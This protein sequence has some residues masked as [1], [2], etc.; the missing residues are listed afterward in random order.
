MSRSALRHLCDVISQKRYKAGTRWIW[1]QRLIFYASVKKKN[2]LAYI[3][4]FVTSAM[5]ASDYTL[6]CI[7]HFTLLSNF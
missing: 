7:L 4:D 1:T 3:L 2:I 6:T 5:W